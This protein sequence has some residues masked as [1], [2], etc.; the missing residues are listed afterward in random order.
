MRGFLSWA[1]E[2]SKQVASILRDWLPQVLQAIKP[3][4]SSEDIDKGTRWAEKLANELQDTAA[5]GV[6]VTPDSIRSPWLN[7]EA[8]ALSKIVGQSYVCPYLHGLAQ[9]DLV[10]PLA[11]FQASLATQEDTKR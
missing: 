1:G 10:G 6:R 5:G 2:T 8:G 3:F 11:M 7:F 4:I 9:V